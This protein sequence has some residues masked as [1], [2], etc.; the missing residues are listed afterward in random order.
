MEKFSGFYGDMIW[1]GG[2]NR[3]DMFIGEDREA[4]LIAWEDG[5]R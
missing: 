2:C 1:K 4:E 3:R 5:K